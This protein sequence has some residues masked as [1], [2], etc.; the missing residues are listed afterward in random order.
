MQRISDRESLQLK[1]EAIIAEVMRY[2]DERETVSHQDT[3]KE[4]KVDNDEEE[5]KV[6]EFYNACRSLCLK[7]LIEM[8]SILAK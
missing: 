1:E 4:E 2:K 6:G 3:G 8:L 7:S 5:Y